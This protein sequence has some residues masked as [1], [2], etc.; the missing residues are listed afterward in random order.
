MCNFVKNEVG[1]GEEWGRM[2]SMGR[3]W[4]RDEVGMGL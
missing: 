2:R 4:G 3:G 1:M